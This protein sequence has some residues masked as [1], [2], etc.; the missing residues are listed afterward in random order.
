MRRACL[1]LLAA[2]LTTAAW[3]EGPSVLRAADGPVF[4]QIKTIPLAAVSTK[5]YKG[6]TTVTPYIAVKDPEALKRLCG[7]LPVFIDVLAQAF[8]DQPLQLANVESDVAARQ[9]KLRDAIESALGIN[10]FEAVYIVHGSREPAYMTAPRAL[11][12]GTRDCQ[13]IGFLP[14]ARPVSA[15]APTVS[16]PR[17]V[18]GIR[19]ALPADDPLAPEM[20]LSDAE[21]ERFLESE[22]KG[23]FPG[24]PPKPEPVPVG[25]WT[26]A[27]FAL[28]GILLM[29]GS[30]IGYKVGKLR[31][32]R[33]RKDRRKKRKERRAGAERRLLDKG[34]PPGLPDR[35][36]G[37]DRRTGDDRR[38]VDRRVGPRPSETD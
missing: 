33:R 30:Y 35:R 38:R 25:L 3:L 24:A 18:E 9:D 20:N 1:G 2:F 36:Q 21:L 28:A 6:R 16:P 11:E 22:L 7:R 13:P 37:A 10:L 5:G 14:W 26:L 34:P 12:G 23:I 19:G 15:A 17:P 31:R 29:A 32:D 27:L 8:E 4:V